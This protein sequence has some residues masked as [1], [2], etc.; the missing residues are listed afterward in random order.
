MKCLDICVDNSYHGVTEDELSGT[1]M[2]AQ[3]GRHEEALSSKM[4][5]AVMGPC[6]SNATA[7]HLHL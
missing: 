4:R 7:A 1:G 3:Q 6:R 2:K 5:L